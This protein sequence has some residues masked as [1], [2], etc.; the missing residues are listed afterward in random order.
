[1]VVVVVRRPAVLHTR[2]QFGHFYADHLHIVRTK[3]HLDWSRG[4]VLR[5]N[6]TGLHHGA[7]VRIEDELEQELVW[8]ACRH[9]VL[10][11]MLSD[12]FSLIC[13][14]TGSPETILFKRF[15]K[16]WRSISLN[17]FIP[18]PESMFEDPMLQILRK[19]LL[20]YLPVALQDNQ[21][22]WMQ[23][24]SML[25]KSICSNINSHYQHGKKTISHNWL[26]L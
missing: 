15:K 17:D 10:E 16:Q 6:K 23:K 2:R 4:V 26:C 24:E 22:G 12:V 8:I 1:M 13:G 25:S 20:E 9:H 19:E 14:S 5:E 21:D 18:A 3:E 7:C 11:I